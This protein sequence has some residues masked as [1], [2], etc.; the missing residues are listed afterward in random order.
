[1][2]SEHRVLNIDIG[3]WSVYFIENIFAPT[4]LVKIFVSWSIE[5]MET[6]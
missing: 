1:M 6:Q 3:I 5:Q 4:A 2:I